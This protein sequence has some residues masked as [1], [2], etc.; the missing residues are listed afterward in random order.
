M[1]PYCHAIFGVY[2]IETVALLPRYFECLFG[3]LKRS[4]V[5]LLPLGSWARSRLPR[6]GVSRG[7]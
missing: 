5:L 1:L 3:A 7:R 4:Q 2:Q 6:I